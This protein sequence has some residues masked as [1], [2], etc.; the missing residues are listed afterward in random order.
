MINPTRTSPT[1]K[2]T[3]RESVSSFFS[4][5][6]RNGFEYIFPVLLI[7]IESFFRTAYPEKDLSFIGPTLASIGLGFLLPLVSIKR[8][9]NTTLS[10]QTIDELKKYNLVVTKEKALFFSEIGLFFLTII[11]GLWIWSLYL[12]IS[13]PSTMWII[14]P[15]PY[16]PGFVSYFLGVFLS[17]TGKRA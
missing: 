10:P 8:D 17:G 12:S 7:I 3:F 14:M 2:K 16:V 5:L 1:H 9:T 4:S 6:F 15:A 13:F 11:I